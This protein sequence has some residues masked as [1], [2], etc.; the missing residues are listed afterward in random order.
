M[1]RDWR[2]ETLLE[3]TSYSS[4]S[5]LISNDTHR[6]VVDTALSL[7]EKDLVSAL[8][9]KG[10]EPADIDIV[11]NTHLHVDHCQ[12]NTLFPRA[13]FYLSRPEWEWTCAF[14]AAIFA[15]STPETVAPTYYPELATYKLATRTIRNAA[16]MARFFWDRARVGTEDRFAWLETANLPDGLDVLPT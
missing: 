13:T 10:L 4:T 3:G 16:R 7:L 15:T 1:S 5:T 11:I 2:V 14:Y 6:I 9:A 8:H 12:N